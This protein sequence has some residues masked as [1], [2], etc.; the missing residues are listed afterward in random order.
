MSFMASVQKN[1]EQKA[2]H[3]LLPTIIEKVALLRGYFI[4][5]LM[6]ITSL[7][8]LTSSKEEKKS[9]IPLTV[10]FLLYYGILNIRCK[11]IFAGDEN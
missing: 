11:K 4:A 9:V 10:R 5:D 6:I 2:R 3:T 1:F 7:F 8:L